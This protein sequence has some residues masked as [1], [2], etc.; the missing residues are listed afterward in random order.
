[1]FDISEEASLFGHIPLSNSDKLGNV[2]FPVPYMFMYGEKDPVYTIDNG[3]A[4]RLTKVHKQ[5]QGTFRTV[6]ECSHMM[7]V[8]NSKGTVNTIINFLVPGS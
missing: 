8:G 4:E 3:A 7:H 1:M 5:G 2:D 6:P